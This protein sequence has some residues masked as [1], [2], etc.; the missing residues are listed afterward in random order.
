MS[1]E[2]PRIAFAPRWTGWLSL[3]SHPQRDDR[4]NQPLVARA[5][6]WA[7]NETFIADGVSTPGVHRG[8]AR[9]SP[10]HS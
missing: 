9:C 4:G 10:C 1:V 2:A 8:D 7:A 5:I 3:L 6:G